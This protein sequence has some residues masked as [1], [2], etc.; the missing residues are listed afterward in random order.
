MI[1]YFNETNA[2]FVHKNDNPVNVPECRPI[3]NFW[4]ILKQHVYKNNWRAKEVKQLY[5]T[6]QYCLN[7]LD[8]S[9]VQQLFHLS[10]Q[11]LI[12]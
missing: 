4:A 10:S 1:N 5:Q 3:K 6:M 11:D 9:L 12:L 2:N 7:K 8:M